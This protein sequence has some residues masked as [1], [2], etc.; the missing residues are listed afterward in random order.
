MCLD[1]NFMTADNIALYTLSD[2]LKECKEATYIISEIVMQEVG[3]E[4]KGY[5]E[6][7]GRTD[8]NMIDA[9]NA[10]HGY[11]MTKERLQAHADSG[12]L[13]LTPQSAGGLMG[14]YESMLNR[15][16]EFKVDAL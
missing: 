6:L 2:L 13:T 15:K 11:G 9:L 3:R 8:S 14:E 10:M 4:I 12:E 7:G 16:T 1:K 5:T